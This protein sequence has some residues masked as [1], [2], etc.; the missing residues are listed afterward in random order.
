[1]QETAAAGGFWGSVPGILTAVAAVL[2][3]GAGLVAALAQAGV[4]RR[5]AAGPDAP[6]GGAAADPSGHWTARVAYPWEVTVDET[7][8]FRVEDGR[9]VGTATYLGAPRAIEG[10]ALAGDR[11]TFSTRAE[12][13]FGQERRAYQNLYD[14]KISGRGILFLLQDTRGYGPVEFTARREG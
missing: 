2:T 4:L 7:F 11:L 6:P 13:I 12:E 9:V 3:A 1:M 10:A 5:R 14:G 8:R